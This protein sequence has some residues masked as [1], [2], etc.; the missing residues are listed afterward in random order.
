MN[1]KE[2]ETT[3]AT[4][5]NKLV[6]AKAKEQA[7]ERYRRRDRDLAEGSFVVEVESS[8]LASLAKT[9]IVIPENA[10]PGDLVFVNFRTV[11]AAVVG[12]NAPTVEFSF[13]G[14]SVLFL[15]SMLPVGFADAMKRLA[16][17][18]GPGADPT[19][20]HEWINFSTSWAV[21]EPVLAGF[22]R[23][24]ETTGSLCAP[25]N[26]RFDHG[27]AEQVG[28]N[29]WRIRADGYECYATTDALSDACCQPADPRDLDDEGLVR[30]ALTA[31]VPLSQLN[32]A[33]AM[34]TAMDLLTQ[35][36]KA[37]PAKS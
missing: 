29:L 4:P 1:A 33:K 32:G 24:M 22:V 13:R 7:V 8:E 14:R 16:K 36:I 3:E 25:S 2:L 11:A 15:K 21:D 37:N 30:M 5:W 28:P 19:P 23:L 6:R 26:M 17:E 18:Q 9:L 10:E 27:S 34:R 31:G 35:Y 12:G 20:D